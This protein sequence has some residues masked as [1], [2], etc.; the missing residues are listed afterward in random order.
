[1]SLLDCKTFREVAGRRGI[2][3][4]TYETTHD[5]FPA[6]D[7]LAA[8]AKSGDRVLLLVREN[9]MDCGTGEALIERLIAC[10]AAP[11]DNANELTAI[12]QELRRYD[13]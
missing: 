9:R 2:Y 7:V 11:R 6:V 10:F 3:P 5:V 12:L 4:P 13:E 8:A 1:M